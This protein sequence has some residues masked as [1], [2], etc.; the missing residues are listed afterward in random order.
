MGDCSDAMSLLEERDALKAE[1][2]ALKAEN[3]RYRVLL[4][5]I[6]PYEVGF[7]VWDKIKEALNETPRKALHGQEDKG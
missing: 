2:S 3:E 7:A 5:G 1:V 6:K 4:D